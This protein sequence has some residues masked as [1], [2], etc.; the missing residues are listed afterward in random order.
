MDPM[1]GN[2][3][4]GRVSGQW[5]TSGALD[6]RWQSEI[7]DGNIFG[8]FHKHFYTWQNAKSIYY[9]SIRLPTLILEVITD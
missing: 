2:N 1:G 4:R 7:P 3:V 5:N 6:V 9:S 8:F